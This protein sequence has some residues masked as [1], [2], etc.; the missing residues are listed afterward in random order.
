[1]NCL[2]VEL[3]SL[4]VLVLVVWSGLILWAG[5]FKLLVVIGGVVPISVRVDWVRGGKNEKE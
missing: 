5:L 4:M 1:M 3:S 2:W